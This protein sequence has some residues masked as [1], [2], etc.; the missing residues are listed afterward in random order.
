MKPEDSQIDV[1]LK[2]Y[3]SH[4]RSGA[5][6]EHLDA[7]ELNAFAEGVAPAAARSRYMSHLAECGDC[8][9]LA[10]QLSIAAGATTRVSIGGLE[11]S[12]SFW[13]K[14]TAFFAPPM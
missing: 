4:A 2:R 8:R 10:T 3:G 7:D 5:A 9:G 11:A 14:L 1:L 12:G 6:A 13:Q